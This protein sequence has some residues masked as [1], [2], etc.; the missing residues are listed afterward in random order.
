M[1][2]GKL[3][4][5]RIEKL[6][7]GDGNNRH[8]DGNGLYLKVV[9]ER[10][11]SWF[12]RYELDGRERWMGLGPLRLF[13]LKA[14]R[15]RA[16]EAARL[17]ADG[18]DP[19]AE[20]HSARAERRAAEA[21]A[22]IDKSRR[23]TFEQC[24]AAFLA[25]HESGWTNAKHRGQWATT[26]K[27]YVFPVIGKLDVAAV[28][29]AD[30]IRVLEHDDLWASRQATGRRVLGRVERILN[31]AKAAGLRA[32]DNP[33]A[34]TGHLRDL[35]PSKRIVEHLPA[36]PYGE[37]PA[38]LAE[39]R[40]REGTSVRALEFTILTAARTGEVVGATWDEIDLDA[41]TWTIPAERMKAE[42]EHRVP[43]S[44]PVVALLRALPREAGNPYLF[45]SP[46]RKGLGLFATALAR[47]L[48]RLR[49]D[50]T[51]HGFR[52]TFRDWCA[53]STSYPNHVCE[54]ALAHSIGN[55]VEK[56]Y[57]RGDLFNKR[58]R[59]MA[60]W[61][62]YVVSYSSSYQGKPSVTPA[63]LIPSALLACP[64]PEI[65]PNPPLPE[66]A[67]T[68]THNRDADRRQPKSANVVVSIRGKR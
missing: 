25:T 37:V 36:L 32:G 49:T 54:Q 17:V 66:I 45:I 35:L 67:P 11:K 62:R 15:R 55:A 16:V 34:W 61:A 52:S 30:V 12:L 33:A 9:S 23:K 20:K 4:Q 26:L 39:L 43:L 5:K 1:R 10:A 63:T 8:H 24:A 14:A 2:R 42:R 56:A 59:L 44:E 53:E 29:T 58:R 60:D 13:D 18:R 3:T 21:A 46:T 68:E 28:A 64:K 19:I 51:V 41:K 47:Q 50:I 31:Y 38:F 65:D 57:R 27:D 7:P 6:V 40:K 48:G 22:R